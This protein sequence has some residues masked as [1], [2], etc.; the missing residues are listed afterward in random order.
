MIRVNIGCGRTPTSGWQNY[1]NS[2]ALKLAKYP[3]IT[4]FLKSLNLLGETQI[5]NIEWNRKNRI[6]FA[7]ATKKLPFNDGSVDVIYTS[8]MLEHLSRIGA[9]NFLIEAKRSLCNGGIL[10]VSVPD[11]KIYINR[12]IENSDADAFMSST[13][14][15]YG[16]LTTLKQKLKLLVVGFR[17]HQWMYDANSLS[18]LLLDAGFNQV[19]V[20][21][22]GNTK[23]KN[24]E[25]LNLSERSS[26][27][28]Y[29]EAVK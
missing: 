28:L 4:F 18:K 29:V 10:R 1:D 7:D 3:L 25:G 19:F 26:Q 2:L 20:L 16:E 5:E 21:E 24:Y 22:A 27:S 15:S 12:Y 14:V 6:K 9:K 11:L 8:H 17:H 13:L 23:I